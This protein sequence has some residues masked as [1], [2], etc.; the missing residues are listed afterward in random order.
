M[1]KVRWSNWYNQLFEIK[2]LQDMACSPSLFFV[3]N[4]ALLI[5]DESSAENIVHKQLH[6]S[7]YRPYLV[8]IRWISILPSFTL[9]SVTALQIKASLRNNRFDFCDIASF[10]RCYDFKSLPWLFKFYK[11]VVR[12]KLIWWF[13]A[14]ERLLL[15]Q[16]LLV[17]ISEHFGKS[18]LIFFWYVRRIPKF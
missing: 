2:V 18:Q 4:C 13:G 6:W 9:Y 7:S 8:C 16:L 10:Q 17:G 14:R 5:T 12:S 3:L 15:I 1:L 11:N